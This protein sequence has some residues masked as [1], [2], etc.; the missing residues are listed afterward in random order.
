LNEEILKIANG[1][2]IWLVASITVLIAVIQAVLYTKLA[3]KTAKK[4]GMEEATCKKAF[5]TG[6]V[7]AIGPSVAV[8][9]IMVGMMSVIGGPLS[10][11]RLS[12]IGSAP[13]ELTAAKVGAEAAGVTFGGPD[14]DKMA[15]ATSWLTM[16]LNGVGWLLFVGLFTSKL[17]TI[18][19]KVS[20]NDTKW[21]AVLSGAA[22]LGVFG[23]LNSGDIKK[24]GTSLI[25]VIVGGISM[26]ILLK[27]AEKVPKIKEYTLGFAMLCGM[28]AA[29]IF[30]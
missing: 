20:G 4:I 27:I 30:A 28:I 25:A 8:F 11:L 17:Q 12:I 2:G 16:T 10:W 24:G 15:L 29:V 13:T 1:T 14:Y 9:I 23:Y 22:M 18:R 19:S 21:L 5:K 26:V 3:N 7:T 6:L